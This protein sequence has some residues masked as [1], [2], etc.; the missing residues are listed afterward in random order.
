MLYRVRRK[1]IAFKGTAGLAEA[2]GLISHG[3]GNI[4]FGGFNLDGG[5]CLAQL[6]LWRMRSVWMWLS[7]P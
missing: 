6:F 3:V 2:V 1:L 7:V 4:L 5:V